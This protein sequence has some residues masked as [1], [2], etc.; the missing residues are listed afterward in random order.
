MGKLPRSPYLNAKFKAAALEFGVALINT[1]SI[2]HTGNKGG[3][4][5]EA[6]R[7]FFRNRLPKR[8]AV[9]EGEAIDLRGQTSPQMDLMFYDQNQCFKLNVETTSILP[10]ESLLATIEVKSALNTGE[11]SKSIEAAKKL[12]SLKPFNSSLA[13]RDVGNNRSTPRLLHCI[14]AYDSNLQT[15]NWLAQE[16]ARLIEACGGE[17]LIDA[18]YVLNR[19]YINIT[20]RIA[21]PEGNDG[22]AITAFYFSILNFIERESSRRPPTPHEKYFAPE[23]RDAWV[24]VK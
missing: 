16:S 23:E 20:S 11:I 19:G 13:G 9:T 2:N 6:L 8:F 14:F 18:V 15:G 1:A 24:K 12:R 21:R 22:G 5:E 4:R 17:H 10:I 7:N 3:A